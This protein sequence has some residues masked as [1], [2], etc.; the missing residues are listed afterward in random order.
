MILTLE[1]MKSVT[2]GAIALTEGEKGVEFHRFTPEQQQMYIKKREDFGKRSFAS[3]GVRFCFQTD[4]R[5]LSIK[6]LLENMG[7]RDF[8]ALEIFVNG[9]R[10]GYLNNFCEEELPQYYSKVSLPVGE[11]AGSFD[12]GPGDKTVT[13]YLPWNMRTYLQELALDDGAYIKPVR[14]CKKL[15]AF[16]DSITQGFEALW[17][18]RRYA[19]RIADMLDAEEINKAIGGERFCPDLAELRDDFTPDYILVAYG[20]NNWA[21][22]TKAV[23][24]EHMPGFFRNLYKHYPTVKTFVLTPIWRKHYQDKTDFDSFFDV[25][26][27]IRQEVADKENMI[28]IPGFDLIPH[29]ET[30][31]SDQVL[32]PNDRGFDHYFENLQREIKKYI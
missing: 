5:K 2:L 10:I 11:F 25:E 15:L 18:S 12:L 23:F 3:S 20:T 29:Y 32:H 27:C 9:Q 19:G 6:V 21:A 16:G 26:N 28:V 14:R 13:V 1:Q 17:P 4:S 22:D 7:A 24:D 8:C 30:L 31:Y